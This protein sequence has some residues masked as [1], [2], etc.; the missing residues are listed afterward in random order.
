MNDKQQEKPVSPQ[1]LAAN[2]KNAK[3]STGP[4]TPKGKQRASQNHYKHG[5]FAQRLFPTQELFDQDAADY[6]R[7]V[8]AYRGHYAPVGDL[9][10]LCVEQIAAE[11]LR[12]ARLLG[13]EQ[14]TL[15]WR[16]PF[17]ARSID[18]IMR[19]ESNV[20]RQLE[21]AIERLE[22]LQE[23]REAESNQFEIS[24]LEAD[25]ASS[26]T[27]DATEDGA[28]APEEVL[29]EEPPDAS[30]PN[31][32]PHTPL[33]TAQPYLEASAEPEPSPQNSEPSKTSAGAT[34]NNPQPPEISTTSTGARI[35]TEENEQAKDP[36]PA[37]KHQSNLGS[38][39]D[40][41]GSSRFIETAEDEKLVER[42]K[43]GYF[44]DLEPPD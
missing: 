10:N 39:E 15:T 38:G 7:V 8:A 11:S 16:T 20:S 14:E 31:N 33:T 41:I 40:S 29:P 28:E 42:I 21:K 43:S 13:H 26:D 6:N 22:R 12:L 35:M 30:T 19:Y 2:R 44:D 37:E 25:D 34:V 18:R 27:D 36:V 32:A 17:E 9:E 1:K 5:F 4:R 23:E 24:N 3:R